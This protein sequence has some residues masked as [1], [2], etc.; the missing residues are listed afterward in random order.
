MT[1]NKRGCHQVTAKSLPEISLVLSEIDNRIETSRQSLTE[2]C[3]ALREILA[4]TQN[5]SLRGKVNRRLWECRKALGECSGFYSQF[6]QDEYL[7]RH[8]FQGKK[9]GTFLEIGGYDGVLAS[10]CLFFEDRLGWTG[11]IVEP[12]PDLAAKIRANRSVPCI[13]VAVGAATGE[14]EF[15]EVQDGYLQ[16]SGLAKTYDQALLKE[17]QSDA[18]YRGQTVPV[19]TLRFDDLLAQANLGAIDLI[20]LDVEGAEMDALSCFPFD[21]LS[22]GAWCIENNNNS[23]EVSQLMANNGYQLVE[24]LGVDDIYIL[25]GGSGGGG[26]GI[27]SGEDAKGSSK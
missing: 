20:S 14:Q 9:N 23:P 4:T 12:V 16:M 27:G 22:V 3:S 15:L 1:G 25:D 24:K 7:F 8:V 6:G 2:A 13:E 10:N 26:G 11:A 17:V 19:K 18:R 5:A 21:E